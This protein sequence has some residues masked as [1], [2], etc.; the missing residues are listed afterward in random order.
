MKCKT[1]NVASSPLKCDSAETFHITFCLF[2]RKMGQQSRLAKGKKVCER[3]SQSTELGHS[4]IQPPQPHSA[5]LTT[6]MSNAVISC[7]QNLDK[8][9][10]CEHDYSNMSK[11]EAMNVAG[12][13]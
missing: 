12:S 8:Q 13:L 10:S 2:I 4:L 9:L 3:V 5:L 7:Y 6:F 1:I 11:E